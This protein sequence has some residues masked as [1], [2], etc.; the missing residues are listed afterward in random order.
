MSA[1]Y[2]R[3]EIEEL[4]RNNLLQF[5]LWTEVTVATETLS[6]KESNIRLLT[7]RPPHKL[8][9]DDEDV[10]TEYVLPVEMS[11]YKTSYLTLEFLDKIF[12]N[13]CPENTKRLTL[14]IIN[15]DG[16]TVFYF[17]YKGIHK[18]KKN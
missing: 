8:S 2:N 10:M 3:S 15:D 11:Q 4:V 1:V 16:T 13:L 14:A 5:H 7:G 17:V 6:W 9:N 12:D 18:P